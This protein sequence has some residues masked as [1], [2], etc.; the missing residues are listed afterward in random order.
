MK[1][2]RRYRSPPIEEA[3]C[4]FRFVGDSSWDLTVP[5]KLQAAL[6]DEFFGKTREQRAIKLNLQINRE[7]PSTFQHDDD[8]L[9]IQLATKDGKRLIGVGRDV[10]S[11]HMLRPY[12]NPDDVESSGWHEFQLLIS[13]ALNAYKNVADAQSVERVGV[14]YVNNIRIPGTNVKI[15][16]YLICA[17]LELDG[18]P[19]N[20]RNFYGRVDYMYED[21]VQLNL[22]YGLLDS[23]S[24]GAQCLVDLDAS[25]R[26]GTSINSDESMK[27]A[28]DLHERVSIAFESLITDKAR[29]LFNADN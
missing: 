5:G 11:V 7:N 12:Q 6:G 10:I 9:K 3:L 28:S 23:S 4:E 1:E 29:D 21:N 13:K 24:T 15:E 20:Y 14:R 17:N 25:W 26:D 19:E 2:R 27:I 18:L 22:S 8:L 16:K